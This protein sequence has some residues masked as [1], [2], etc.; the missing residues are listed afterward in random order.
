MNLIGTNLGFALA[1]GMLTGPLSEAIRR[2][3]W[4]Y[5]QSVDVIYTGGQFKESADVR[6]TGQIGEAV[7][8]AGGR[9]LNDPAN[10]NVSVE[11][12]FSSIIKSDQLRNLIITLEHRVEGVENIDEQRR[13]S[14]GARLYYR[15]VF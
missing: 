15:I 13:A 14:N 1:S 11:L 4:G 10:A 12:P 9:V 5:V 3:T 8:R 7:I 2:N 6:L